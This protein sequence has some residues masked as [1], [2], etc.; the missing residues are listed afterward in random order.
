MLFDELWGKSTP[1]SWARVPRGTFSAAIGAFLFGSTGIM[2]TAG[3]AGVS[4]ATMTGFLITTAITTWA[5]TALAPKPNMGSSRGL[6]AN[7]RE[8]AGPFDIKQT[9]WDD[10]IE[11]ANTILQRVEKPAMG[12]LVGMK[13]GNG[14][15]YLKGY[16][17]GFCIGDLSVFLG[18]KGLKYLPTKRLK[19]FWRDKNVI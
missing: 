5:L 18:D 7:N 12:D 4:L 8:A 11:A 17:C 13:L 14:H 10:P 15:Y 2:A 1:N 16:I 19:L 6:L 3:F 9:E